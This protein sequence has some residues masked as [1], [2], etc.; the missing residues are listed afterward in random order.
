[1]SSYR[2]MRTL[3]FFDLP[4][5]IASERKS[6]A[7]FRKALVKDGFLMLQE[8]VYCKL[9][10][11]ATAADNV[12]ERVK[13]YLPKEGSVIMLTITEKQFENMDLC[14]GKISGTIMDNDSKMVIL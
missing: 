11:N 13:K 6:A 2:Y 5:V 7:A 12:R 9:S 1:M 8:S 4:T 3:L 10:L 14:L